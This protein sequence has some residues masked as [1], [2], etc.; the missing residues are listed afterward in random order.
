MKITAIIAASILLASPSFATIAIDQLKNKEMIIFTSFSRNADTGKVNE[1]VKLK[2][3]TDEVS[4]ELVRA[5]IDGVEVELVSASG[6]NLVI[7]TTAYSQSDDG[8]EE[9]TIATPTPE[10][11]RG[12]T[13]F[14]AIRNE[15]DSP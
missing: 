11:N 9:F 6:R 3:Q 13:T 4:V 10:P 2:R 14:F 8:T 12:A 15:T 7:F 5:F 1:T